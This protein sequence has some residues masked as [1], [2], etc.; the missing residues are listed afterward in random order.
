MRNE[1]IDKKCY[2]H[3]KDREMLK[4]IIFKE[5][6]NNVLNLRFVVG[7]LLCVILTISC[8]IILTHQYQQELKDYNTCISLE[9]D[10]LNNYAHL[11]RIGGMIK[12]QKPPEQFRPLII[13]I[14]RDA[15][16]GSFD[17]NPLPVLFPHIDFLFI[18]TIIMS[19]IAIL[20]SYDSVTGERERGT[21]RLITANSLTRAKILLGKWT[22]GTI[23]MLI[24]FILSLLV[25]VLYINIHPQ[26]QW[27]EFTFATFFL[28]LTA[29]IT[30][31]S[32]FYLLGLMV[33]TFSRYSSTSI[34]TSLFLWVL[35]ILVIPNAS[36]YISAQLYR[37]PSVNKI[38][39]EVNRIRGIER[40]DLGR[41]L[42]GEVRDKFENEYGS[43]F[44]NYLSMSK[45]E[46]N[47]QVAVDPEF[48]K[49]HDAYV[50]QIQKAW[51]EANRI[52]RE[53]AVKISEELNIKSKTQTKISKN[54]ACI[55]PY[56][57]FV[58]VATDLTGTGLRS[59]NY[60]TRVKSEY[61][62]LLREYILKK[63]A[64]AWEKNP[65][66]DSNAFLDVSDR[67]R[68]SFKEE[69]LKER[70]YAVMPYWGILV[71][72]NILFF[73]GAFVKFIRYDVR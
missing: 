16:L 35:L 15:D 6:H 47:Q 31:L 46:I 32:A 19:L 23:S 43:V 58:Y 9:D 52:Q 66:F 42:S 21:L 36:P 44:G 53:K 18:V 72:F 49:I 28:L 38:E 11:N 63:A 73:T 70:L 8:V 59:L 48:K 4:V 7:L 60:F 39:R 57:N 62:R 14:P 51:D 24:P 40:D 61:G 45:D 3:W 56:A 65:T 27:D 26:I 41:K 30:F 67:P 64:E 17:D 12:P 1:L 37:I 10:F 20:F 2:I 13:G 69:P 71:F 54:L 68:F 50:V 25:S 29:S 55:S 5:L 33:S 22:G 34:L